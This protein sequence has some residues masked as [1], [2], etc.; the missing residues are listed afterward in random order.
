MISKRGVCKDYMTRRGGKKVE[1]E[2]NGERIK[3]SKEE[4]FRLKK[5]M[6]DDRS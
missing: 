1:R 5:G 3:H 4:N 6:D 2:M